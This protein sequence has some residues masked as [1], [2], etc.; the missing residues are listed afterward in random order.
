MRKLILAALL[1]AVG[2]T[3]TPALADPPPWAPAHSRRAQERQEM[4]DS[5]GR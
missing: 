1:G 3:A 2:A 5:S 4:Y